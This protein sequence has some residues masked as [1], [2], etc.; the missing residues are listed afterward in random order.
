MGCILKG[1]KMLFCS[2]IFVLLFLPL[3]VAGYFLLN[4]WNNCAS[5]C[6][7]LAASLYFY[8]YFNVSYLFLLLGSLAVNYSIGYFLWSYRKRWLLI[9]GVTL[10]LVLLGYCKYYDFFVANLTALF[11]TDWVLKNMLLPL[12]ISFFT[13]QQISYLSDVFNGE[14]K[15]RYSPLTYSLF[16]TFFPQ[17]VAGPIVLANEMMPQFADKKN[18]EINFAN[19]SCGIFVFS[20]GLAKKMLLADS[21]APIGDALFVMAS[22]GCMDVITGSLAYAFQIYFDFSGY[23]DMAIGIGLMFNIMLPVNF[24]SPYKSLNIQE[25]WRTWHITLGRFLVNFIYFPMGGNRKGKLRTYFNLIFTFF[26]SGLWHGANWLFVFWG[27]LNGV[28]VAIHRLWSKDLNMKMPKWAAFIVTFLFVWLSQIFVKCRDMGHAFDVFAALGDFSPEKH[29]LFAEEFS[30]SEI[31]LFII[32][33]W[34]IFFMPATDFFRRTFKPALWNLLL[35]L[36]LIVWSILS[37]NKI[38]PFIYFN[39]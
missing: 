36:T 13:F 22:P 26:I 17:L 12:G 16:V 11:G 39:F 37:F 8:A 35:S 21:F 25:F 38:S 18:C 30:S 33:I 31:T 29:A 2:Y 20:L 23:S 7:L 1:V 24:L 32:G 6:W 19:L 10:N 4:K 34:I 28:A 14:L 3:T 5:R 27:T 9:L 15:E